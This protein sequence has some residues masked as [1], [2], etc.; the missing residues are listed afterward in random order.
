M[1]KASDSIH[2]SVLASPRPGVWAPHRQGEQEQNPED[3]DNASQRTILVCAFSGKSGIWNAL[4]Q[5]GKIF[6]MRLVSVAIA[7]ASHRPDVCLNGPRYAFCS[8]TRHP[9]QSAQ[10]ES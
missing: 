4:F 5:R 10:P 9:R 3:A 7:D 8:K 2:L 6:F 1:Q